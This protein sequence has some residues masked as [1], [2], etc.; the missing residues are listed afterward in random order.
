MQKNYKSGLKLWSINTDY[1]LEEAKRLYQQ[2]YFEYIELYIVPDTT[3]TLKKWKM[4]DIPFILHAPHYVHGINLADKDKFEYNK[5]IYAQVETFRKEL[6]AE[7]TVIHAGTNGTIEETIR[8]LLI[9]NPK[10][11]LIENKPAHPPHFE[12]R[13]CR[14]HSIEE[15][16]QIIAA[17]H[18]GFCLDIGHALCTANY[19]GYDPYEFLEKFNS[20]H[21]VLYHISDGDIHSPHDQHLHIGTGNY[22]FSKIFSLINDTLSISIETVK[23]SQTT[24]NDFITDMER[25]NAV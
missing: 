23:D 2:G 12:S 16:A 6:N 13:I 22:D 20:L 17:A 11:F 8:Q 5:K 7:Y 14:G 24:L 21:P 18:C 19:Y 3:A 1:Y 15:I 10:N 9:I 25:F 4:L